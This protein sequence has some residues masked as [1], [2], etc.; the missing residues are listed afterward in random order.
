MKPR[1]RHSRVGAA[2]LVLAC[3]AVSALLLA[4]CARPESAGPAPV[5]A[6]PAAA[7]P[8]ASAVPDAPEPG[9]P[10]ATQPPPQAAPSPRATG[11]A[12]VTPPAPEGTPTPAPAPTA[13]AAAAASPPPTSPAASAPA[14]VDPGGPVAV[15]APKPGLTRV[16]VQKCGACHKKQRESWAASA[17]ARRTPPLDC[18]GCH[19]AGSEYAPLAVMKDPRKARAAGLVQP[20]AAF[21]Q[22]CHRHGWQADMLSRAHAHKAPAAP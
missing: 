7:T 8:V 19:G 16:G 5:V 4:A 2:S 11:L 20:D 13:P 17:H 14:V 10:P 15:A 3:T 12:P 1:E 9:A 6:S 22:T 18:E 21:C